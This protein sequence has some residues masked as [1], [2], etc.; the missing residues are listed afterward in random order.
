MYV[1]CVKQHDHST[2]L[3][4]PAAGY[5]SI[6]PAEELAAIAAGRRTAGLPSWKEFK[7]DMEEGDVRFPSIAHPFLFAGEVQCQVWLDREP[8]LGGRVGWWQWQGP[9]AVSTLM[10]K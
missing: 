2:L 3:P 7:E 6:L 10:C 8:R 4:A 1:C 5:T 9:P